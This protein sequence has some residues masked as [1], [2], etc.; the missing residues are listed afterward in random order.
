M[1]NLF[2]TI[3]LSFLLLS[4]FQSNAQTLVSGGVTVGFASPQGSGV[5]ESAG[6]IDVDGGLSYAVQGYYHPSDFNLGLGLFYG[7]TILA[8][9]DTSIDAFGMTVIGAS[10]RYNLNE[11]G[12]T[13]FGSL[14][15]GLMQLSTP[16]VSSGGTVLVESRKGSA[17]AIQPTIGLSFGGFQLSVDYL[18]PG[19]ITIDGVTSDNKIGYLSYNLG[20]I[21]QLEL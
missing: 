20:Y 17:F 7:S 9:V 18:L 12:F 1:K 2:K 3:C 5:G 11:E 6:L 15:L 8:S 14:A 4:F 10:A 19:N 21:H 13:P 16:S